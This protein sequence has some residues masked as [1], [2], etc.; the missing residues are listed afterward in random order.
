MAKYFSVTNTRELS[1]GRSFN[2]AGE[3]KAGA[4]YRNDDY[5]VDFVTYAGVLLACVREHIAD[6]N[7]P[8]IIYNTDKHG[9][10]YPI[11][12]SKDGVGRYWEFVVG[13]IPGGVDVRQFV[14]ILMF[15]EYKQLTESKFNSHQEQINKTIKFE[16]QTLTQADQTTARSNISAASN[17][18]LE[19]VKGALTQ[20]KEQTGQTLEEHRAELDTT[21]KFTPHTLSAEQQEQARSNI[22]AASNSHTYSLDNKLR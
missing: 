15:E 12:I 3:L 13:G 7:T 8:T 19:N 20:Y 1:R 21:V 14:N 17:E 6:D 2:F 10:S 16:N 9:F 5:T 11:G 18:E 4:H 22:S